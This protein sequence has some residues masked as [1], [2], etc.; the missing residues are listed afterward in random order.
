M[1]NCFGCK[2]YDDSVDCCNADDL[3]PM[4]EYYKGVTDGIDSFAETLLSRL[5]DAIHQKDVES[6][7]NLIKEIAEEV[8][9]QKNDT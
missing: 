9:E 7:S 2:Y 1:S 3:C 4:D 8:K 6:M 5:T